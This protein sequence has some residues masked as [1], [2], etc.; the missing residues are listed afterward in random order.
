[1]SAT[2][3]YTFDSTGTACLNVFWISACIFLIL[4]G[5]HLR[6]RASLRLPRPS[7]KNDNQ[8]WVRLVQ[9]GAIGQNDAGWV[10]LQE[11]TRSYDLVLSTAFLWLGSVAIVLFLGGGVISL[12]L[13]GSPLS[14]TVLDFGLLSNMVFLTFLIGGGLGLADGF[15]RLRSATAGRLTY[16]DLQPRR[17]A[18]YRSPVFRW[19]MLALIALVIIETSVLA[20]FLGPVLPVNL[21]G[22]TLSLPTNFWTLGIVPAVM[23]LLL[24]AGEVVMLSIARLPRLL[25]TSDP[26]TAQRADN[27]LRALIIG[28]VQCYQLYTMGFLLSSLNSLLLQ[29]ISS[30]WPDLLSLAVFMLP[31]IV[32]VLGSSLP[33]RYGR[34]GGRISDWSWRPMRVTP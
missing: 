2:L 26:Q 1:M 15:W 19:L 14:L 5:L 10:V 16:G 23:L 18:D 34:L 33:G 7:R 3:A 11:F 9:W 21:G 25:V 31:S 17:L 27:F 12:A 28:L 13:T 30:S 29:D 24:V 32:I 20:P 6:A 22:M 8:W 4:R